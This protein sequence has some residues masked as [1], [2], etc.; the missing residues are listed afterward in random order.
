[1][2]ITFIANRYLHQPLQSILELH[3]G[4]HALLET[5]ADQCAPPHAAMAAAEAQ[6]SQSANTASAVRPEQ[7]VQ[8]LIIP[9]LGVGVRVYNLI[10]P[11]YGQ[12]TIVEQAG[13]K[14]KV[15]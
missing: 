3:P 4:S 8:S 11:D 7:P 2:L 5:A 12:G 15:H 10:K 9:E 1:M 14:R 13:D 6:M